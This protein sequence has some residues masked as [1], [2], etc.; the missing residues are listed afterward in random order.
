MT[1]N[2][3]VTKNATLPDSASKT[4]FHNMVDGA[5]ASG[6]VNFSDLTGSAAQSQVPKLTS[7]GNLVDTGA[8]TTASA[9]AGDVMYNNGTNWVRLAK[10][11]ASKVLAMNSGATAPEWATNYPLEG[12]ATGKNI[13][14]TVAF[15]IA[16]G[17]TPGTNINITATSIFNGPSIT[18]ATNL[19]KNGSS[20]SFALTTDGTAITLDITENVI[21]VLGTYVQTHDIKNSSTTAGD[22]FYPRGTAS[23]NN[24]LIKVT[25]TGTNSDS[26]IL[27]VVSSAGDALLIVMTFIT[28]S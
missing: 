26:D 25:Q 12:Y 6:T 16:A 20:G 8:L 2:L 28:S 13:F 14:R 24:I 1:V 21:A 9:A 3:T 4:D 27:A 15:N 19:A 11:A 7:S 5:T 10:G 17:G 23:S 22:I 18:N